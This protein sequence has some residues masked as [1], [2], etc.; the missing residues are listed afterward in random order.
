MGEYLSVNQFYGKLFSETMATSGLFNE[1]EFIPTIFTFDID[2]NSLIIHN[3]EIAQVGTDIPYYDR[4]SS[5]PRKYFIAESL[6][7][8]L[9]LMPWESYFSYYG[10]AGFYIGTPPSPQNYHY[11]HQF[12]RTSLEGAKGYVR[13]G[14]Y[15]NPDIDKCWLLCGY[16]GPHSDDG[17]YSATY[18]DIDTIQSPYY[19]PEEIRSKV[20]AWVLNVFYGGNDP[21]KY[22]IERISPESN[23]F[24][25]NQS[26]RLEYGLFTIGGIKLDAEITYSV[27]SLGT[28]WG[29]NNPDILTYYGGAGS[30]SIKVE[31]V[32]EGNSYTLFPTF[33]GTGFN[34]PYGGGGNSGIG[35][36][37][38]NFGNGFFGRPE[39]S[40]PIGNDV[41][42]VSVE[43]DPAA[44]GLYTRYLMT[45]NQLGHYSDYL[46]DTNLGL[47]AVK[48]LIGIIYGDPIQSI[49]NVVSYPF[50]ISSMT[51]IDIRTGTLYWGNIDTQIT[52]T[53]L[54]TNSV[55][56]DWGTINFDLF[57]GNFLDY[58]PHTK[59]ELYLPWG[60]GMVN[61]D[62]GEC[63]PGSLK[64][65][66]SIELD[67]GTC[68]HSVIGNNNSV[69]GVYE[70]ICGRTI[71]ISAADTSGKA[72]RVATA[73]VG[74]AVG[75]AA[76][77]GAAITKSDAGFAK[78]MAAKTP[79][80]NRA[81]SYS[82]QAKSYSY[83][84]SQQSKRAKRAA[85]LAS[86]S[87]LAATRSPGHVSRTG[88]FSGNTQS[89]TV[90][91]PYV[92]LSR[93]T[94][95]VPEE[96]G[97]H[98][99]YPS[100]IYKALGTLRGYTE[101]SSIHLNGILATAEELEELDGILKD[102]VI[103]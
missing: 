27:D 100:N 43:N 41:P 61:I 96:Y 88:S 59:I 38:G 57:W 40:D 52:A 97:H 30:T 49:I 36:G 86:A 37:G 26:S 67:K 95:S 17:V 91:Y 28:G 75:A 3:L 94:Q 98:F 21:S 99:G 87:G 76:G 101:I 81:R 74:A 78:Q 55:Y 42:L 90:Q 23:I 44:W 62:P 12:W 70:G 66:T 56:I 7:S 32:Y 54:T 35:G 22:H 93:P 29:F 25:V 69:I 68:V 9:A 82:E 73:A 102:G 31:A 10:S 14:A 46:W 4:S 77:I 89:M 51:G 79:D 63:L 1:S 92:I 2:P 19:T 13:V 6:S 20:K 47:L 60:T 58:S 83:T 64:I 103:F 80:P 24:E 39:N 71:P 16:V 18:I 84:A 85:V 34:D 45:G 65:I 33:R 50:N 15:Y 8:E 48:E 11:E 53:R 5:T 72:L